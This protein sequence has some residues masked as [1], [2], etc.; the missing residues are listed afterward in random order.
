MLTNVCINNFTR[1][2]E[3]IA[4]II[5]DLLFLSLIY[6]NKDMDAC[7]ISAVHLNY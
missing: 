6:I 2:S 3:T 1:V 4:I 7:I 5:T